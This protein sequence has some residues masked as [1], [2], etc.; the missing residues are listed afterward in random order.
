[1]LSEFRDPVAS[2]ADALWARHAIFVPHERLLKPREHSFPFV[3]KDQP[4]STWRSPKS[5]SALGYY[6]IESQS[7]AV[8]EQS[9]KKLSF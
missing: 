7:Q 5:Q 2:Y 4:E 9:P 8:I 3:Q 6:S 1:M